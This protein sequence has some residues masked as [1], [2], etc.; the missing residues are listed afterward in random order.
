MT[1]GER[2]KSRRKQLGFSAEY[3]ADK[4][5]CSPSTIYRY[6]NGDIEKMPLD[7]LAPLASI[8]LVSPEYLLNGSGIEKTADPKVDGLSPKENELLALYRG[9]NPDGQRYILQ[10]AEFANSLEEYRLS[11]APTAKSGA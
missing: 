10:Q 6:E 7:V 11:P 5:G 1:T 4:L 3:V 2:M 8:L 9:V